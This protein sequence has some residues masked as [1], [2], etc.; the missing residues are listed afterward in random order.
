MVLGVQWREGGTKEWYWAYLVLL[1]KCF[2]ASAVRRQRAG[3]SQVE[4]HPWAG[5]SN[6]LILRHP[7]PFPRTKDGPRRMA[8]G[9]WSRVQEAPCTKGAGG[10][11]ELGCWWTFR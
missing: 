10:R 1:R 8:M 6:Q 2:C 9:P 4:R 11:E 7:W 3:D 5:S